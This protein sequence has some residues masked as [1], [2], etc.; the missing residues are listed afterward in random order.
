MKANRPLVV[1]LSS[2]SSYPTGLATVANNLVPFL[3]TLEPIVLARSSQIEKWRT[4]MPR[5]DVV[6]IPDDMS[7]DHGKIGHAKR[8]LWI[9]RK[10]GPLVADLNGLLFS[11]V[12]E[13][14]VFQPV[15]S[16]VLLFDFI[17]LYS[18]PWFHPLHLYSKHYVPRVAANCLQVISISNATASMLGSVS[19]R[20]I[21][22]ITVPLAV[23]REVFRAVGTPSQNH[24][25]CLGRWQDYK[26]V[27]TA[28]RAFISLQRDDLELWLAGPP[29][30]GFDRLVEL[31]REAGNSNVRYIG[32]PPDNQLAALYEASLGLVFM[33]RYEGFGLP[34]LEAMASGTAVIA[35]SIPAIEEV[36]GGAA[37]LADPH[38]VA[39]VAAHMLTLADEPRSRFEH[40]EAGKA[41]AAKFSWERSGQLLVSALKQL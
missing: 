14:P 27:E 1:N 40:V 28:V 32:C 15:P 30:D 6:S 37:L 20:R 16:V 18:K 7:S 39:T 3:D 29:H 35:S 2:V 10:L 21:C 26:N 19:S 38:D 22:S 11:P 33:S 12:P 31:A 23:D 17:P 34:V 24:F 5:A 4:A 9:E 36:S 41:H 8:L 25:L 13:A